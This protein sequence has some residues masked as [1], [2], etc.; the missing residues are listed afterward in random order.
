[1]SAHTSAFEGVADLSA[2]VNVLAK[3]VQQTIDAQT[4]AQTD[5]AASTSE[6]GRVALYAASP[7][8]PW[9]R[10][11]G[12]DLAKTEYADLYAAIGAFYNRTDDPDDATWDR[13]RVPSLVSIRHQDGQDPST[14]AELHYYVS[15]K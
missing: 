12:S 5:A 10:C 15:T 2:R 13:F 1:M 6:V 9:I 4:D 3:Q 8:G 7:P 14:G 11:D